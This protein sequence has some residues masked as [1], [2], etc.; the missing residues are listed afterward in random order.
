MRVEPCADFIVSAAA[1]WSILGGAA[2][3]AARRGRRNSLKSQM[4]VSKVCQ[5]RTYVI[6]LAC[7]TIIFRGCLAS[8]LRRGDRGYMLQGV[9]CYSDDI[10]GVY[11][12]VVH[13]YDLAYADS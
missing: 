11:L 2:A 9:I 7:S 3:V 10:Y 1:R 8:N 6:K 4:L 13:I 12:F 5:Q